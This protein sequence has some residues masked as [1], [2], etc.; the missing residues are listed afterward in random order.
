MASLV[1]I[2]ARVQKVLLEIGKLEEA[3]FEELL[4]LVKRAAG[5]VE[6]KQKGVEL[7]RSLKTIPW[8]MGSQFLEALLPLYFLK[9]SSTKP[10]D[11]IVGDICFTLSV[12][13]DL[14]EKPNSERLDRIGSRLSQLL[15]V[16]SIDEALRARTLSWEAACVFSRARILTD[17]RPVFAA[18]AQ[19]KPRGAIIV[20]SLKLSYLQNGQERDA[21]FTLDAK[22][23]SDLSSVLERAKVK[24]NTLQTFLAST[25]LHPIDLPSEE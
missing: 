18:D 24:E 2:P 21:Y 10:V 15:S 5:A 11:R 22:D 16:E 4:S 17:I 7:A 1:R 6:S 14:A 9:N 20:H 23:L 19:G 13:H 3:S 25:D 8:D 12:S